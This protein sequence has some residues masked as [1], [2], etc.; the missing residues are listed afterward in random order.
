MSAEPTPVV[1]R[2][3]A[4]TGRATLIAQADGVPADRRRPP[5]TPG[6]WDEC[7]FWKDRRD[8]RAGL[9]WFDTRIAWTCADLVEVAVRSEGRLELVLLWKDGSLENAI[10][11]TDRFHEEDKQW[12]EEA[13][14]ALAKLL[15]LPCRRIDA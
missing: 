6:G 13:G 7:F 14:A 2:I 11:R 9:T 1:L 8:D 3:A 10:L 12:F 5:I 4:W 15:G